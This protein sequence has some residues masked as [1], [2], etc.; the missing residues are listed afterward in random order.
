MNYENHSEE[1]VIKEAILKA[2]YNFYTGKASKQGIP[3]SLVND[4]RIKHEAERILNK[5]L[6]LRRDVRPALSFL[7]EAGYIQ[8]E[9]GYYSIRNKGIAFFEG[10]SKF[11]IPEQNSKAMDIETTVPT[12]DFIQN[13]EMVPILKRD[14]DEIT[15]CLKTECWKAAII[16]CG[17]SIEGIL[18][19]LLKQN[20]MNALKSKSAQKDKGGT[21]LSLEDWSLTALINTA[22]ELS[23]IREEIKGLSHTIKEFRNLVHPAKET[24]G[25]Y[26]LQKEEAESASTILKI[27]IRDL[28]QRLI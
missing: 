10:I 9:K 23:L 5:S 15:K 16:L 19:D 26:T 1:D 13:K 27:L 24:E 4:V 25:S 6:D 28:A 22:S 21:A 7:S 3:R 17:S 12:F 2:V 11:M 18:Y 20:E 14:Y 8:E